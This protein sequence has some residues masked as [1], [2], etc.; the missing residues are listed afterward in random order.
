[1]LY[2]L[3]KDLSIPVWQQRTNCSY[4]TKIFNPL[5]LVLLNNHL[6]CQANALLDKMLAVLELP[7]TTICKAIVS[8]DKYLFQISALQAKSI[9]ILGSFNKLQYLQHAQ[10]FTTFSP[11]HLLENPSDKRKAF[12]VL[13]KQKEFLQQHG[14]L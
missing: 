4:S 9:L 7:A 13:K 10:T 2:Q 5:C 6:S 1:M 12:M 8:E 3:L 14:K 11:E